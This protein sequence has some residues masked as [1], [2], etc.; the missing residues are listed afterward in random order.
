MSQPIKGYRELTS[1]EISLINEVK[2]LG[3]VIEEKLL[4]LRNIPNADLRWLA[5]AKTDM[6][7][8]LM[9][10]IRAIA[11]PEGF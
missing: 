9:A 5:I 2:E 11:R 4:D 8:G 10:A 1:K 6:Q 7:T 3:L